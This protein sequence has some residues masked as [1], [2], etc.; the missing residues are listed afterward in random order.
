MSVSIDKDNH[1]QCNQ[2]HT[3]Q[4]DALTGFKGAVPV[5]VLAAVKAKIRGQFGMGEDTENLQ[6]V[7]DTA[8]R[9]IDQLARIDAEYPPYEAVLAPKSP[10]EPT[11]AFVD[12]SASEIVP[13]QLA[14]EEQ[15]IAVPVPES[16]KPVKKK[17]S[18]KVQPSVEISKKTGKP[19]RVMK[20]YSLEDEVF[21]LDGD[22][23][24]E[25]IMDR[26]NFA[27][28]KQVYGLRTYLKDRRSKNK[29]E[30]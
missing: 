2:V 22:P 7:R 11:P 28:K 9:L 18:K 12:S 23:S 24:I 14:E 30:D 29:L 6:I 13:A 10:V 15:E 17:K 20:S 4:K 19:K 27:D 8:A 5:S 26:F 21:V 25:D 3:V 16:N 1:V